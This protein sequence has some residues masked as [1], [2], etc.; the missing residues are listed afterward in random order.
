MKLFCSVSQIAVSSRRTPAGVY[1]T[2]SAG[3]MTR[4]MASANS[5]STAAAKGTIT[6]LRRKLNVGRR[7]VLTL[8]LVRNVQF[9]VPD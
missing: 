9:F 8:L 6:G 1:R 7:V 3:S 2:C 4:Q 5:S